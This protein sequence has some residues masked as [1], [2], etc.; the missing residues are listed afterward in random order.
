MPRK[1]RLII[2]PGEVEALQLTPE[3]V[4]RAE[5]WTGGVQVVQGDPLDSNLKFVALNIPTEKE[6]AV[7]AEPNWW[8]LKHPDGHF[9]TMGPEEFEAKYELAVDDGG[10]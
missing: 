3:K 6:G 4:Q 2:P 7:R 10:A 8:I 5:A 1:F 9:S